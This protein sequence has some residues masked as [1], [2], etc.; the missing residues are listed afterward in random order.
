MLIRIREY[1]NH[2]VSGSMTLGVMMNS[3]SRLTEK[4]ERLLKR[5]PRIGMSPCSG[6][7]F[8]SC[9]CVLVLKPPRTSVSPLL[10][11]TLD[12]A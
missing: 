7:L 2:K 4:I 9:V 8:E 5:L 11:V 6:V 3:S 1:S 12:V 10:S